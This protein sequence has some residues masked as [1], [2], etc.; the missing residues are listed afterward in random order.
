[1]TISSNSYLCHFSLYL[2]KIIA[3]TFP[4]KCIFLYGYGLQIIFFF[5]ALKVGRGTILGLTFIFL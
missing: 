1:M 4:V 3:S 5:R 2:Q